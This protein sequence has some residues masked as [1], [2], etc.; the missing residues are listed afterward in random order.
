MHP[1][2]IVMTPEQLA[3]LAKD[4]K[5]DVMRELSKQETPYYQGAYSP[6]WLGIREEIQMKLQ[7]DYNNGC[8]HWYQ[9]QTGL[10]AAFRLA[11]RKEGIKNLRSVEGGKLR[12]FYTELFELIDR[13]RDESVEVVSE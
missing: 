11:F 1:N 3:A 9:N 5:A 8:G 2:A 12:N 7:G 6:E 4:I 10:Y 13:Y